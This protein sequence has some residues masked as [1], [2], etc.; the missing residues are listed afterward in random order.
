MV[1]LPMAQR[2]K[3]G[4]LA[5]HA[6]CPAETIR[7]YERLRLLPAPERTAANYRV[8][9]REHVERLAFVRNCRSLDMSLEEIRQLLRV[10]DTPDRNHQTAHHLLDE[11]IAHVGARLAELRLLERQLKALRRRCGPARADD[12]CAILDGLGRGAPRSKSTRASRH[13]RG[14]HHE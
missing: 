5:R 14:S 3:I 10:R 9:G 6:Q 1:K 12:A 7:Y 4:D 8:Y 13:V 11:H 2:F